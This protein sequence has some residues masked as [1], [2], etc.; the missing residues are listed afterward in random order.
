MVGNIGMKM[1]FEATNQGTHT[2]VLGNSF[3]NIYLLWTFGKW[4]ICCLIILH[5]K[6]R[7]ERSPFIIYTLDAGASLHVS[8][9]PANKHIQHALMEKGRGS[10]HN[11]EIWNFN[12]CCK[13]FNDRPRSCSRSG[14]GFLK[15]LPAA[16]SR[17]G[18]SAKTILWM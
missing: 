11:F 9:V 4:W 3:D 12:K 8:S 17:S 16:K 1:H 14:W 7:K 15:W 5:S 6:I 13:A 2:L 18:K 10:P